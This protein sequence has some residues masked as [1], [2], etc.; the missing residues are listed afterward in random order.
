VTVPPL[1]PTASTPPRRRR[2]WDIVVTIILL[3][4]PPVALVLT[5]LADTFLVFGGA[6]S[7]NDTD[8]AQSLAFVVLFVCVG[9][10][11]LGTV[12]SIVVLVKRHRAWWIALLAAVVVCGA[13]FLSLD[14]W[15]SVIG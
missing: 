9:V 10:G 14:N 1:S 11:I 5:A 2:A 13:C 15:T 8:S 7:P 4:V 3:L 6:D 12:V